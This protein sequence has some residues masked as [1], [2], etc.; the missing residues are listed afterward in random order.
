MMPEEA[1]PNESARRLLGCAAVLVA[2]QMLIWLSGVGGADLHLVFG[3]SAVLLAVLA[4]FR[5]GAAGGRLSCEAAGRLVQS[6]LPF[7]FLGL[8]YFVVW[9]LH[10]G[11][12]YY[13]FEF[14]NYDLGIYS[15]VAFNTAQGHFMYSSILA[16]SH[17]G[18]HVS[19]VTALFAPLYA[20]RPSVY[21][22][23]GAQCLS[24]A[25]VP[26][27]LRDLCRAVIPD[28]RRA[29]W[30]ALALSLL[31]GIYP[32]MAAAMRFPFHPSSLAMPWVIACFTAVWSRRWGRAALLLPVLLL[33]KENLTLVWIGLGLMMIASGRD[34]RAG[35]LLIVAGGIAAWVCLKVIIPFF[36][37]G[38]WGQGGRVDP[39]ADPVL[40]AWY[41][42]R[43]LAPVLALPL[44][45]WRYGIAAL[46]PI[47][48]NL[49][50]GYRPQYST[51][52]QYDD[53]I[54]ALLFAA[55]VPGI[56]TLRFRIGAWWTPRRSLMAACAVYATVLLQLERSPAGDAWANPPEP[57]HRQMNAELR[58]LSAEFPGIWMYVQAHLGPHLHRHEMRQ[59]PIKARDCGTWK[60]RDN[61]LL[62]LSTN[63]HA[64]GFT[65]LGEC[66]AEI[67]RH[68]RRYRRLTEFETVQVYHVGRHSTQAR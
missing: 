28:A 56:E 3:W 62:V 50:T 46:P 45:G 38:D 32:P 34:R 12:R 63:A 18:E 43:L 33:F 65:D 30:I 39:L 2:A 36:R 42:F 44:V 5:I 58:R 25:A 24:F 61:S 11:V 53:V 7:L 41:L 35:V 13:R 67:E 54:A 19:P 40:K 52:Y 14:A 55:C 9:M 57:V 49:S 22:L 60:Y 16:H 15:N 27:L 59:F 68:P 4:S 29:G 48:L 64:W 23:F 26:L 20:L 51:A 1:Q 47:L 37:D 21:W 17:L 6:P 8:L 10:Q 66:I 31:W